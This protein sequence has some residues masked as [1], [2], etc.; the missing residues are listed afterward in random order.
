[1][2]GCPR[3]VCAALFVF[4]MLVIGACAARGGSAAP[5]PQPAADVNAYPPLPNDAAP[6]ASPRALTTANAMGPGVNFGKMLEV[7]FFSG[8][9][10]RSLRRDSSASS[11]RRA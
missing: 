7:G 5:S 6:G 4:T 8:S 11:S 2:A 3:N 10:T 1:V 9:I